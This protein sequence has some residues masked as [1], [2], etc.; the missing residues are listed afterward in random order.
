MTKIIQAFRVSGK[1][2]GTASYG[3]LAG[4][5]DAQQSICLNSTASFCFEND[6]VPG[7]LRFW[8]GTIVRMVYRPQNGA[9][10]LV[11]KR[12]DLKDIPADLYLVCKWFSPVLHNSTVLTATKYLHNND[13]STADLKEVEAKY[14]ISSVDLTYDEVTKHYCLDN[15][16]LDIIVKYINDTSNAYAAEEPLVEEEEVA[17]EVGKKRR[18]SK[19]C[20]APEV[21]EVASSL[22]ST[23]TRTGRITKVTTRFS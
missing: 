16:D 19:K 6:T 20:D 17:E 9:K 3:L 10:K 12:V 1:P 8:I 5:A 13:V 11:H 14:I 21:P 22:S 4:N 2:T 7:G 18:I 15:D 23:T